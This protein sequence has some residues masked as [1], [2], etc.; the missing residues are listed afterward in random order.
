MLKSACRVI[1]PSTI[2]NLIAMEAPKYGSG[3]YSIDQ[4]LDIFNTAITA[5]IPTKIESLH[6]T[7]ESAYVLIHTGNWGCGVYGGN[8]ILIAL[9]QIISAQIIGIK[10]LIYHTYDSRSTNDYKA[11]I[12]LFNN[13]LIEENKKLKIMDILV[14]IQNSVFRLECNKIILK[15]FLNLF[16][17]KS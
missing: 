3:N 9:L 10:Y 12:K 7:K 5:F 11:A 8:K 13:L 15:F 14:K 17:S 4:I 6:E 1:S 2:T 16:Y